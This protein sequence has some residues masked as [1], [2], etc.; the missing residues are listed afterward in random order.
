MLVHELGGPDWSFTAHGPEEF[1]K[2]MS[3]GISE[4]I[5][6]AAFVVAVSSFGRSQLFRN[7]A[8]EH[9]SKIKIVHCGLDKDFH[10]GQLNAPT[11]PN[12]LVCVGRLCEQ[13][14]HLLLLDAARKLH[15]AGIHFELV[16]AGDGEMRPDLES[17]IEQYQLKNVV[18]I[19]G[20]LNSAQIRKEIL[21]ARALVLPSFAEGLPVVIMEAMALRRPVITTYVAGIPELV[22]PGEHGWL[23]PSGDIDKLVSAMQIC[24][25]RPLE[26]LAR[27][28][29]AARARVLERHDID[30]EAAKLGDLISAGVKAKEA[31]ELGD[32]IPA[33]LKAAA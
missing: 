30:K 24:L 10:H 3:I 27:M 2:P 33:G 32:L 6:R 15:Q 16:L 14:G 28:G 11:V 22:H 17:L 4:K 26:D 21:A 23:V 9:W 29:D 19:T 7:I 20:W 25:E 12:R 1:D 18:R 5:K 31:A 8:Y 13:K